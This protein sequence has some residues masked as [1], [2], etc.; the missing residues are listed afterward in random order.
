VDLGR[1]VCERFRSGEGRLRVITLEPA[2]DL[3]MRK[4]MR[5]DQLGIGI[6]PTT[7]LIESVNEAWRDAE[8]RQQPLALLVDQKLRRPLKKILARTTP[9]IGL[10]SYQEV[11]N[12]VII[13]SVVMLHQESIIA[14]DGVPEIAVAGRAGTADG[15]T[16]RKDA[17]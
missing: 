5:N 1:L 12:D 17:A 9:D 16:G 3:Y 6:G 7:R 13:D 10:I 4:T 8:R 14:Q 2:L 15:G 11:P